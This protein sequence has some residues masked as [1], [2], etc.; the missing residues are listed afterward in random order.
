[1]KTAYQYLPGAT[2]WRRFDG[3][4]DVRGYRAPK[5]WVAFAHSIDQH[6]ITGKPLSQSQWWIEETFE[7]DDE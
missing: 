4:G 2:R 6:P 3:H 7:G 5:G 1:M